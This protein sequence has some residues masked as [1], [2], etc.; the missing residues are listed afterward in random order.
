MA[1]YTV[2]QV[3]KAWDDSGQDFDKTQ[4]ALG[5]S[6]A[7]LY[8][9]INAIKAGPAAAPAPVATVQPA[10]APVPA[11]EALK[12]D[13]LLA[14]AQG[15]ATLPP[16]PAAGGGVTIKRDA[17]GKLD[18][19]IVEGPLDLSPYIPPTDA[20]IVGYKPRK[21]YFEALKTY[22]ASDANVLLVGEAG[23]GKTSL[24]RF[25]A[26]SLK[27]PY[28]EVSCDA[29]LGFQELFGQ[30]NISDGT[31]HFVEGLFLKFIQQPCVILLDEVNA[32]DS[33]KNFKL[34]QL[35][36]SRE[37]FVKEASRGL[38]KLYRVHDKCFIILA[39]NPPT[40]KY[41]GVNRFNVALLDRVE[42]IEVEEFSIEEVREI[43]PAHPEKD[44]LIKFYGE[45]RQVI[46][47]QSLRTTFSI[48]SL[49]SVLGNLSIGFNLRD[50]L[51]HA[52]LNKVKFS[53]GEDAYGA[54]FK[55]ASTIWDLTGKKRGE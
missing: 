31:S 20:E 35:L 36:N 32:L 49:K 42:A 54:L 23:V 37:T 6:R 34:H 11:P 48:R 17:L 50:A 8:R 24:A 15:K 9:Y 22:Y 25:L 47:A 40:A 46:K 43:L 19:K 51:S 44:K 41:N 28:L 39:G 2:E 16:A 7:S 33:A 52:F 45:A 3:K 29:L 21:Q 12:A 38:G 13:D 14:E 18:P 30:V 10:A 53:A 27:L 4:V 26:H 1:K 5:I 55:L